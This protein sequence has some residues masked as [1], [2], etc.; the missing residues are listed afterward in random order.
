MA[1]RTVEV[2]WVPRSRGSWATFSA[3]RQ[4]SARLWGDLVERHH[5]IRRLNWTWPSKAR[6][7]RWA[8]RRYPNLSAQ[9]AQQV[10]G[11]FCEAV[12]SSR[13]LRAN[14]HTRARYPWK[15]PKYR[16]VPYTNQDARLRDGV[17]RLPNGK[18]GALLV[19]LLTT[20]MLPGRLMEARL[21]FGRVLLVCEV[22]DAAR[23][24]GP[25]IGIDLGVNTL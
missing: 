24:S 9:S 12:E 2:S 6:W 3:A 5:R 1:Y 16:A 19:R 15:K 23:P 22:P 20:V 17:L 10:I 11:E 25:T 7:Q 14:G 4:E 13:R 8:K 21:E 18:A